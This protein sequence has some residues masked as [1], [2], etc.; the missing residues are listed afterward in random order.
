MGRPTSENF[1]KFRREVRE[2]FENKDFPANRAYSTKT[3]KRTRYIL[4]RKVLYRLSLLP[5]I[6][7]TSDSSRFD[8][9]KISNSRMYTQL[10]SMTE[11][12]WRR[13]EWSL[14]R[15][16]RRR[17]R[18]RRCLEGGKVCEWRSPHHRQRSTRVE[19]CSALQ[20]VLV[21]PK[22]A[23]SRGHRNRITLPIDL[24]HVLVNPHHAVLELGMSVK[25]QWQPTHVIPL[26][27]NGNESSEFAGNFAPSLPKIKVSAHD[28]KDVITHLWTGMDYMTPTASPFPV[29]STESMLRDLRPPTNNR[30]TAMLVL[31]GTTRVSRHQ[32]GKTNLDLLEQDIMSGSGTSWAICKSAPWPRYNHARIPPLSF[33]QA[34]C[35]SCR[36]TNS[37]K[38]LKAIVNVTS[39]LTQNRPYQS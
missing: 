2:I 1:A 18:R 26:A 35:P 33:L 27:G 31:S 10:P 25:P 9:I 23:V 3:V 37:I 39:H 21:N 34:G 14:H 30:F 29:W 13:M 22:W 17:R 11:H 7:L 6:S 24:L 19:V 16:R 8:R 20:H 12:E 38:A 15:R 28:F 4:F 32:K 36:R 5:T